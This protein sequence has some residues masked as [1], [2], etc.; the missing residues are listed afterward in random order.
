MDPMG[1][2]C[3]GVCVDDSVGVPELSVAVGSV[4]D[5]V[6]VS[7]PLPVETNLSPGQL[8]MTGISLSVEKHTVHAIMVL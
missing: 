3:P 1:K 4:Q 6:P 2:D 8:I 5:I 7:D